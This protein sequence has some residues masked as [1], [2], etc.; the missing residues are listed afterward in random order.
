MTKYVTYAVYRRNCEFGS[1]FTDYKAENQGRGAAE[2]SC[3]NDAIG[4]AEKGGIGDGR[5]R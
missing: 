3:P 5:N 2:E 1:W 4:G